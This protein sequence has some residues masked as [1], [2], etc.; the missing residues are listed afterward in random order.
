MKRTLLRPGFKKLK[1]TVILAMFIIAASY[2]DAKDVSRSDGRKN[3]GPVT[4]NMTGTTD[5]TITVHVKIDN[6][7]TDQFFIVI[8]NATEGELYKEKFA[9]HIFEKNYTL[10][11]PENENGY[12]FFVSSKNKALSQKFSIKTVTTYVE[13]VTVTKL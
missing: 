7:G 13:D 9:D 3:A 8:E 6:P 5:S 4:V 10:P 12:S 1:Q 2:V 11:R